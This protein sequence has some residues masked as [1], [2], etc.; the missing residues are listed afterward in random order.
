MLIILVANTTQRTEEKKADDTQ[1][2]QSKILSIFAALGPFNERV[3]Y[4]INN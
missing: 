3:S 4:Q 2:V 1:T